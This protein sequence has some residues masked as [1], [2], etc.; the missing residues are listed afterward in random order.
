[1]EGN[2]APVITREQLI[3]EL[4]SKKKV[5]LLDSREKEEF[6]VSHL[7]NAKWIGYKDYQFEVLKNVSKDTEIVIYCS[8]GYRSGKT[9]EKL[10]EQGFTNVYNL[11]G[12]IF[13]W[14]NN[15]KPLENSKGASTKNVH[16]YNSK[17]S[18]YLNP[19]VTQPI[20]K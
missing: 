20:V 3:K 4:D 1:M 13:D 12:G 7:P 19:K 11:H 18:E 17:W 10:I 16:G 14:A 9:A 2:S 8:V 15:Q 6:E 5:V